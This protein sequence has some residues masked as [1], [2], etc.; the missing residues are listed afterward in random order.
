M[1]RLFRLAWIPLLLITAGCSFDPQAQ[2]RK[3]VENGNKF[4]AKGKF[5]EASI[6][7]RRAVAKDAK[8]GEAYYR[9]GLVSEK[10]GAFSD[11][12]AAFRRTIDIQKNN[13]DAMKRLGD[14]YWVAYA[15]EAT[16]SRAKERHKGLLMEFE[17]VTKN[18]LK[19]DPKSFDGLR[20]S[21]YLN[22]ANGDLKAAIEDFEKAEQTKPYDPDL[23][24]VHARV[25]VEDKRLPEAEK[26][27]RAILDHNKNYVPV[28]N[29]L[30]ALYF[31]QNRVNDTEQILR[32]CVENNP[33]QEDQRLVLANFYHATRRPQDMERVLQ[34]LLAN[35]K[36]F[37]FG[38]LRVGAFFL[39]LRDFDRARRE[40]EAGV[41]EGG[42]NKRVYQHEIVGLLALQGKSGEAMAMAE[43]LVK[44]DPKDSVALAQRSA[45]AITAGDPQKLN[46]AVTD[47]QSLVTKNPQNAVYRFQLGR[48]L[49]MKGQI[50][51]ARTH[52]E[53]AVRLRA[54]I[55]AVKVLLAQVYLKKGDFPKAIDLADSV[56]KSQPG[57]VQARIVRTACLLGTKDVKRAKE[58]LEQIVRAAPNSSDALFQ[59]AIIS[60]GEKNYKDATNFFEQ[61]KKAN[62]NDTRGQMG[63][64]EVA[65]AQNNHEAAI[66]M[67]R[68]AVAADPNR[69]DSK[70]Q[71]ANVLARAGKYDEAL[72]I[73]QQMAQA[74]PKSAE[75][76]LKVG[77]LYRLKGDI[78]SAIEN[79]KKAAALAPNQ[80]APQMRIA[81][82]YE[83]VGRRSEAKPIYEQ[84][85]RMDPANV[86]ALNNLAFAKAE[87]GS[88]LDQALA[89]AQRA[90]QH[91]PNDPNI[92]DTLGWVYIKKN[93]SDD[94]V[95]I[96]E[97]LVTKNPSNATYH[98]HLAMALFQKGDRPNAKKQCEQALQNNPSKEDAGKIKDL[99][100]K[101][102]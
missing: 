87:D 78:N 33:K 73:F 55:T 4:F 48:A 43:D 77:E 39:N 30:A 68:D 14:I 64:M 23:G 19:Q 93:L 71:L 70:V 35:K 18:L 85:L 61:M 24:M 26:L 89:Y 96:F 20:F 37:P 79:Y 10:L 16:D 69:R 57:N 88:D 72:G 42:Q 7:Y 9:L 34:E 40:F 91:V 60:F 29:F 75:Y 76:V 51:E 102:S 52:L 90:K 38:H 5:K 25:L 49:F 65:L 59:L 92:A 67:A 2:S 50:E 53:E 12:A 94:A 44:S 31:G 100:S 54:N 83:T 74:D 56:I 62:P 41:A 99:L 32:E 8:N 98:Y 22:M 17:D 84:V 13:L 97:E 81:L 95:R 6:M 80:A 63:L 21:G 66:Q 1:L 86:V 46:T 28:Y 58:E 47:L 82:M 45:L 27:A 11:A 36:D 15:S 101:V 3:M